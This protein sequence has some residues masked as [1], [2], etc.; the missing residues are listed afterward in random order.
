MPQTSINRL[1]TPL[2]QLYLKRLS[3]HF[4]PHGRVGATTHGQL[5]FRSAARIRSGIVII[6]VND[7]NVANHTIEISQELGTAYG[8]VGGT[9]SG[10]TVTGGRAWDVVDYAAAGLVALSASDS[11][12]P[13]LGARDV[14]V[15]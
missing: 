14:L 15:P 2:Q 13:S 6:E 10:G 12:P 3:R 9:P 5:H 7:N 11:S 1:Q 8:A 4:R